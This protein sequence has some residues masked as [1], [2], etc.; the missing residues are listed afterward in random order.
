MLTSP[1][2]PW[3]IRVRERLVR[4]EGR[5]KSPEFGNVTE[6]LVYRRQFQHQPQASTRYHADPLGPQQAYSH[7]HPQVQHS[8]SGPQGGQ[9]VGNYPSY[10]S[11]TSGS[12]SRTGQQQQQV[13]EEEAGE[14]EAVKTEGL[15]RSRKAVLPSQIRRRERSTEDPWRG[16]GEEELVVYRMQREAEAEEP[17]RGGLG[18]RP[19][20]EE[21]EYTSCLQ[22]AERRPR[23][24]ENADRAHK[25]P[26]ATHI[27]PRTSHTG[28]G[29]SSSTTALSRSV[30]DAGN[31]RGPNQ[32][33]LQ[34]QTKEPQ[35]VREGESLSNGESHQDTRVSVAQ[36][37]HSYMESTTT[38][39]TSRRNEL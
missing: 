33:T 35:E 36:L 7:H 37:R 28:P 26:A 34:H 15:L 13:E 11:M 39:P 10:L 2:S 1:L 18:G 29:S 32:R 30:S 5:Q 3:R 38:P 16:R 12:T 27:E 8:Q 23:E 4:E 17:V 20:R 6:G 19:R 24:R 22:A 25:R 21:A 31:Q 9:E 14:A